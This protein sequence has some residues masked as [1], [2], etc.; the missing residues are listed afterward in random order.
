V[1]GLLVS[2]IICVLLL[3][4][5]WYCLGLLPMPEFVRTILTVIVALI[6]LTVLLRHYAVVL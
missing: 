4:L 2:L 3:A 6:V 1:I 5:L